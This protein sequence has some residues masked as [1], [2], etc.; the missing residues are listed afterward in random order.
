LG[1]TFVRAVVALLDAVTREP[2]LNAES[3]RALKTNDILP[4]A[5][6]AAAA[7]VRAVVAHLAGV[8]AAVAIA[9]N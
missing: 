3:A 8:A 9:V 2:P 6:R 4:G 7:R 1:L 5:V